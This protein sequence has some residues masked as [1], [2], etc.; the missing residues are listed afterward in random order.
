MKFLFF[1]LVGVG[2][3]FLCPT[4]ALA[5]ETGLTVTPV[6]QEVTLATDES[7][8]RFSITLTNQTDGPLVLRPS[9]VDFGSLDESGGVAFLGASDNLVRKYSLASWMRPEKDI[10]SLEAGE[11]EDLRVVIENRESL[12]PGGHYGAVLFTIGNEE[13]DAKENVVAVNQLLSVLVFAKK[14]G[15]EIYRLNLLDR[16]WERSLLFGLSQTSLRFQNEG[17]VHI[18]PRG[19]VTLTDPLGRVVEKGIINTESGLVLPESQRTFVTKLSLVTPLLIPGRYTL[20]TDYR[21]DGQEAFETAV[22]TIALLP[23][24]TFVA[25]LVLGIGFFGLRLRKK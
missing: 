9:V 3:A 13:G 8:A 15:G 21:Y 22:D 2:F 16:T 18:V 23:W 7:E 1:V 25:I 4:H 11:S 6:F 5:G 19:I 10:V 17:N 12:S 20:T 14:E 24:P